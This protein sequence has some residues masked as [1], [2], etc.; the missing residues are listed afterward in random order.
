M[1]VL[2]FG[3]AAS[4]EMAYRGTGQGRF[5][6]RRI[7]RLY[8]ALS[9]VLQTKFAPGFLSLFT[10]PVIF[11]QQPFSLSSVDIA[12]SLSALMPFFPMQL[13]RRQLSVAYPR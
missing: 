5:A 7:V 9:R 11:A 4:S 3:A 8:T 10:V 13:C 2:S 6:S 1:K 12:Q